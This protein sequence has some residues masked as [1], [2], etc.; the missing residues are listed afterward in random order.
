MEDNDLASFILDDDGLE[1]HLNALQADLRGNVPTSSDESID[2]ATDLDVLAEDLNT[3]ARWRKEENEKARNPKTSYLEDKL[4]ATAEI[5]RQRA[6][7][8]RKAPESR[9]PEEN[10]FPTMK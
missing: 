6:S 5:A 7:V 10:F 4:L 9:T 1:N 3:L 8:V 2:E